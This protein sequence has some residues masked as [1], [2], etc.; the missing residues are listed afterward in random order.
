[1]TKTM[2]TGAVALLS[3]TLLALL[4]ALSSASLNMA[5]AEEPE[6][7]GSEA[8]ESTYL[9]YAEYATESSTVPTYT[10]NGM[11]HEPGVVLHAVDTSGKGGDFII[12]H[13]APAYGGK[14]FTVKY[15]DNIN[16]GDGFVTIT[17]SAA[18]KEDKS[19]INADEPFVKTFK[20]NKAS[21]TGAK[22]TL[23]KSKYAYKA[24]PIKPSPLVT[25]KEMYLIEGIDYKL[26]YVH[27]Q[28]VGTATVRV[29]GMG[30]F[31]DEISKA[32]TITRANIANMKITLS[33]DMFRYNGEKKKP[34]V[35]VMNGTHKLTR[36]T[37]YT[38]T[39]YKNRDIGTA[40][41]VVKRVDGSDKYYGYKTLTYKIIPRPVKLKTVTATPA[42]MKL[43]WSRST[44]SKT[45]NV[46]RALEGSST[47]K[48]IDRISDTT[49][50]DKTVKQGKTYK[51]YIRAVKGV[52]GVLYKSAKSNVMKAAYTTT[53]LEIKSVTTSG[54]SLIVAWGAIPN[55]TTYTLN[56]RVD[57]GNWT[58]VYSGSS[59]SYT[60][61][62]VVSGKTY[63]YQ[64]RV[65]VAGN[66]VKSNIAKGKLGTS[67]VTLGVT[68]F[69]SKGFKASWNKIAGE[70]NY[71]LRW[72]PNSTFSGYHFST[73]T[74]TS[75][76]IDPTYTTKG[77]TWYVKVRGYHVVNGQNVYGAWSTVKKIVL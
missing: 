61:T 24:E 20:I 18:L 27:P 47:W 26:T 23:S 34:T 31:K 74:T 48:K 55:V 17:P 53:P 66:E 69:G 45:F 35:T 40:K 33:Q 67:S 9:L 56:R 44:G 51:Y 50:I 54:N 4:M 60:D 36:N 49:Y 28:R 21:I 52:D 76:S 70:T 14:A 1:M 19:L 57:G 58:R 63:E 22:A 12:K 65:T 71:E 72:A 38:L 75:F 7:D 5:W 59:L 15:K 6:G 25:Y 13:D 11:A 39:F 42:G 29:I 2:K 10:Y 68:N 64:V 37:H 41:V 32:Y 43:N 77:Q 30:N 73:V 16:A 3:A 8:P 62:T 46:Y